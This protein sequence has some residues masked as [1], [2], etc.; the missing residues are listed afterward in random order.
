MTFGYLAWGNISMH[1][2]DHGAVSMTAMMGEM[3]HTVN[4]VKLQGTH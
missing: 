3:F 1:T 2:D 4:L